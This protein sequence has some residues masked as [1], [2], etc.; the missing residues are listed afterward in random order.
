MVEADAEIRIVQRRIELQRSLERGLDLASL[1]RGREPLASEHVPLHQWRIRPSQIE[2]G[3]CALWL[4][5]GPPGVGQDSRRGRICET[6][7][8]QTAFGIDENLPPQRDHA[9]RLAG[10]SRS[11]RTGLLQLRIDAIELRV[12]DRVVDGPE[13]AA[14]GERRPGRRRKEECHSE[15]ACGPRAHPGLPTPQYIAKARR[16]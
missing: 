7:I 4:A 2:P 8:E 1:A 9:E 15:S 14:F 11:G 16:S 10:L 6:P 3:F 12:K 13:P 5:A